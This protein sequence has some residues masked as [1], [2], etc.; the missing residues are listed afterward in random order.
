[1]T[2]AK[3]INMADNIAK[4]T[5]LRNLAIAQLTVGFLLFCFGMAEQ[6]MADSFPRVGYFGIWNGILVSRITSLSIVTCY[7]QIVV[8]VYRSQILI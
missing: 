6:F 8:Y 7:T 3:Y 2:S 1:M 4:V 5:K